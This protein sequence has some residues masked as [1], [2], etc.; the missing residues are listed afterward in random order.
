MN[1]Q[2]IIELYWNRDERAIPETAQ[3]YG[4]YCRAIAHN[5]LFDAQDAEEC[6]NDTWLHTWNAIPPNRPRV[7]SAFLGR[8]IRNLALNRYQR[9]RA[10]KRGGSEL[11]LVYEELAECV[12]GRESVEQTM[13]ARELTQALN[14][15][16]AAQ[17]PKHRKLFV[18]RYWYAERVADIAKQTGMTENHVSVILHRQRAALRVFLAERG[19][20]L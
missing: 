18:R 20:D 2:E 10:Q 16:L 15:F 17:S 9:S 4:A 8:I 11:N 6:V 12:S 13:D 1:D 3:V 7:F 19:F 14:D 5:I